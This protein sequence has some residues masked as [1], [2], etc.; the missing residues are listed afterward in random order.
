MAGKRGRGLD[1]QP[2]AGNGRGVQ[3]LQ[4]DLPLRYAPPSVRRHGLQAA[5]I[6]P[7][8]G[9]RLPA[10]GFWS[11][12]MPVSVAWDFPYID[13]MDC[14]ALWATLTYDVDHNGA[15][16]LFGLP[17]PNWLTA[18]RQGYHPTWCLR[19]PVAKH[20]AARPAPIRY[21]ARV[22]EYYHAT[23]G[24]D[25]SFSGMGRNPEKHPTTWL[26]EQPY[27]LDELGAVIPKGWRRPRP[28]T[29]FS[30]NCDLF[31]AVCRAASRSPL[32]CIEIARG[33]VG[34][35]CEAHDK[36]L[37]PLAEVRAI[38]KSVE[39]YREQWQR[40]GHKPAWIERQR[41]RGHKGKGIAKRGPINRSLFETVTNEQARPW[42]AEGISRRWW[43]ELRRRKRSAQ[44]PI[45]IMC[46]GG[47][48]RELPRPP[49][50]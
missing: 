16:G 47:G 29:T 22:A 9:H 33:L 11:G 39:R 31:L 3:Q 1:R 5:H 10:G 37:L 41:R 15:T 12:R 26:R 40:D 8:V 45:Q 20:D 46:L 14:G 36:P 23:L 49:G 6:R 50:R 2:A 21:M 35:I 25:P 43:Y 13:L 42:E 34:E 30:R 18:T 17:V 38:A 32:S 44:K 28:V 19:A 24:A 27:G 48:G 4:L 7:R